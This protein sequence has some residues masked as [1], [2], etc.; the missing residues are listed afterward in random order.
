MPKRF[1]SRYRLDLLGIEGAQT[2]MRRPAEEHGRPF[3]PEAATR[4]VDDLRQMRVQ[5]GD[6][7]IEEHGPHVEPVQLQVVCRQLWSSLST[8]PARSIGLADVIA[9]GRVDDALA[10]FYDD[11]VREAAQ[12]TG[13]REREIRA[14]FEDDLITEQGFRAQVLDGPGERGPKVVRALEN[15]HVIRADSR[16]GINWYEISHDRL[17]APIRASNA[18]WRD[19]NL[20]TLQ[21][22]APLWDAQSR[23]AGL[24]ITGDVL[25]EAK[26]WAAAHPGDLLSVDRDYLHASEEEERRVERERRSSRRNKMLAVLSTTIGIIA[27]AALVIALFATRASSR[28]KAE[29]QQ[30]QTDAATKAVVKLLRSSEGSSPDLRGVDLPNAQ[31]Q[32]IY[33]PYVGLTGA[34]LRGADL[35]G[36]TLTGADL[37]GATMSGVALRGADLAGANLTGADLTG[38]DLAL[39]NLTDANLTSVVWDNATCPDGTL[40]S[41]HQQTCTDHLRPAGGTFSG[42]LVGPRSETR[43]FDR[44]DVQRCRSPALPPR[45][46]RGCELD[47]GAVS[48]R[49]RLGQG[50]QDV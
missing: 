41:D 18:A 34:Q 30:A 13:A 27:I 10:G 24:L 20:S 26:A 22:E 21:R 29:T 36:A 45:A 23:P 19:A 32:H 25:A 31:L 38:A 28:A 11:A 7:V 1:S 44:R 8:T 37:E 42:E 48:Q 43:G 12:A 40:A 9:L 4:L 15:A 5:R 33:L 35:T 46:R 17:V 2:A 14:W 47:Q 3:S 6:S 49:P 50:W 39:A 16:R